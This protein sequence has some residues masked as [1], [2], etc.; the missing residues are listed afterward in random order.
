[1]EIDQ[2]QR[3][4]DKTHRNQT[5][6]LTSTDF[7]GKAIIHFIIAFAESIVIVNSRQ[8]SK[9]NPRE[10]AWI[11]YKSYIHI[12]STNEAHSRM[13]E[14]IHTSEDDN[15]TTSKSISTNYTGGTSAQSN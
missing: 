8:V 9:R 14:H 12:Y 7:R 3:T 13:A 11:S 10:A 6:D 5:I 1:M 2:G 15:R 4:K